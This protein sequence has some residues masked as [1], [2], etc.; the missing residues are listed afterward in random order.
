MTGQPETLTEVA[1]EAAVNE[2]LGLLE[3]AGVQQVQHHAIASSKLGLQPLRALPDDVPSDLP[4]LVSILQDDTVAC[5]TTK[6][7]GSRSSHAGTF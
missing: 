6:A 2:G 3:A 7:H 1:V 4:L 5:T